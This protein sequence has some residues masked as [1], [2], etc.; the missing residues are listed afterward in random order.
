MY[1]GVLLL[2]DVLVFNLDILSCVLL[3][4]V[5]CVYDVNLTYKYRV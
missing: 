3:C 2:S 1:L 4:N 5:L